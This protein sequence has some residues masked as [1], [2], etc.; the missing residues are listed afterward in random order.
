VSNAVDRCPT[1]G[2]SLAE[3]DRVWQQGRGPWVAYLD[4]TGWYPGRRDEWAE[5]RWQ[6]VDLAR[7][8]KPAPPRQV[9]GRYLGGHP[10]LPRP[11]RVRLTRTEQAVVIATPG[12]WLTRP[13]R[14]AVPL[15]AIRSVT[16]Q[17]TTETTLDDALVTAAIGGARSGPLGLAFGAAIGRRRWTVRTVH[18]Q[19]HLDHEP[20]ELVFRAIDERTSSGPASL[21]RIF[22]P[23]RS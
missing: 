9:T 1:C 11:A 15:G 21:A 3:S 7:T 5:V 20:A 10:A 16:V 22:E 14:V 18:V 8:R 2:R 13:P 6:P 19:V 23:E 17:R 12:W 4:A